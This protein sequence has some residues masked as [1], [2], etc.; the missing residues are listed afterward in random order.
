M[1]RAGVIATMLA[2]VVV[3][4]LLGASDVRGGGGALVGAG[5][6]TGY[7]LTATIETDVTNGPCTLFQIGVDQ[8]TGAPIYQ[9]IC[10]GLTAIRVQKAG[11][12]T[13]AI[14]FSSYVHGFVNECT[15]ITNNLDLN[16]TTFNRFTGL[17]SGFIDTQ[18]V[19]SSLLQQF[20][21]P[22]KAA[23]TSQAYV[24][25]NDVDYGGV[26]RKVLS[27]TAVIQFQP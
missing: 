23:I 2:L 14:F 13:A 20:G 21:D 24:V 7:A 18:T 10:K 16:T 1:R 15:D 8:Q 22:N 4:S 5:K 19:L 25:C 11:A 6:T 3:V 12:N 17:I 9:S 26:K 27:F